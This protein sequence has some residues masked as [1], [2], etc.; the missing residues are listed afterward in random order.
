[1]SISTL[2]LDRAIGAVLASAAGDALGSQ[3][4]FGPALSDDVVP[5]F[6]RGVF[7]HDVGEWTDDTSMAMPLLDALA[8]GTDLTN[9]QVQARIVTTWVDWARTSKD[10]GSQTRA[11][12]SRIGGP[13]TAEAALASSRASHERSGRSGGNG[14][15]M[16]TGPIALG[17]LDREPAELVDAAGAIARLTHWEDDNADACA[18]W[19]LAIRHAIL[20]GE[21]DMRAQTAFLP[22]ERRA[23]WIGLIDEADAPGAG[24]RDF[25]TGNGWVVRAFQGA[26]AAVTGAASLTDA[27][28]RA[29]RGGGDTDTVAAIA[30]ALA[31]AVF[32]GSA[33]PLSWQR[34][35]HG[36]PEYTVA[37]LVRRAVLAARGGKPDAE[38]W[39]TAARQPVYP[40]SDFLAKHPHDHGVWIG[41]LA[42]LDRLPAEVD[43]VVSLCRVG[44]AQV[45]GDLESVQVWLIDQDGRNPNLDLVL[46][47]AADAVAALRAEGRV[48]FL[49]C[50]EG[51]SRTAA[52][53]ALYG[54]RNRD[55][56]LNRAWAEVAT[57][58]PGFAPQAF[59]QDAVRRVVEADRAAGARRMP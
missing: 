5:W 57:V 45:P 38:G 17:Y 32:G 50:A 42:A 7:G 47:E 1:M 46:S 30:G 25:R 39:P 24:P 54:A 59:L 3:F 9:P 35:L 28:H 19:C 18:L 27:L 11:V 52:V 15:L 36:W 41:S 51:R 49:H 13:V 53:S 20:T 4:E 12:L 21:L 43:A 58:L 2:Q 56:E 34:I 40:R 26:L 6:G 23:R 8:E 14:S 22:S 37:D 10:V 33:V 16:R 48:V 29:V 31:G 55:V 44:S